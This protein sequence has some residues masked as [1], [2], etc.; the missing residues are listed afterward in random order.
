MKEYKETITYHYVTITGMITDSNS[1]ETYLRVQS[2][3]NEF[4]IKYSEFKNYN[5]DNDIPYGMLIFV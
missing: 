1:G 3:G 4:Y 2:W 5:I